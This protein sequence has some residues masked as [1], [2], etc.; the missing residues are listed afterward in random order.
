[1]AYILIVD[2]DEDFSLAVAIALRHAGHETKVLHETSGALDEIARRAPDLL[3]LDAMF[4][5]D[6][7]AGF[8]LARAVH[9]RFAGMRRIPVLM[10]TAVNERLPLG[11]S[12]KGLDD[13]RLPVDAF[14]EKPVDLDA[15]AE[16]VRG[17]LR[18]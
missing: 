14:M 5:E 7:R 1:M 18:G 9:E 13:A 2:D 8:H 11:F 6:K 3:I 17:L 12:P 4:P 15:L 10:L 16:R